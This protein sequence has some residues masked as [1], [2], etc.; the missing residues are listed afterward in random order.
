[1]AFFVGG[2]DKEMKKL[3]VFS[4]V[5]L[6]VLFISGQ[7]GALLIDRGG[8]MIYDS[9]QNITW[10]QDTNYFLSLGIDKIG[11]SDYSSPYFHGRLTGSDAHYWA[12]NLEYGGYDDWRLPKTIDL[13]E[14][15]DLRPGEGYEGPSSS[16]LNIT[17]SEMGYMFYVNL[18]NSAERGL[19]NSGPFVNMMTDDIYWSGTLRVGE[20][21]MWF[22]SFDT[23]YQGSADPDNIGYAWAVRDGDV[24]P[25]PA[26]MLLLGAGL[27]GL[28][29]LGRKSFR[30]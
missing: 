22:F 13:A 17:N 5:M 7:A 16:G 20:G 12:I 18:G 10:L 28:A 9:D 24:V 29:A 2:K 19:A 11:V 27:V 3:W 25:E 6:F 23:G 8:G 1:L 21:D 30:K 14:G 15:R 4:C 26:T